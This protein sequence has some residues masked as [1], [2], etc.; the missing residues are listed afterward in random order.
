[1]PTKRLIRTLGGLHCSVGP[2]LGRAAFPGMAAPAVLLDD[3][4]AHASPGSDKKEGTRRQSRKRRSLPLDAYLIPRQS[5][6]S[7]TGSR[8][9]ARRQICY[10]TLIR[11][12]AEPGS[13][14]TGQ[15]CSA[16]VGPELAR[17]RSS[18]RVVSWL[19]RDRAQE[20]LYEPM[21]GN[22]RVGLLS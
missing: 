6:I 3:S 10:R 5:S 21:A 22:L 14:F 15:G 8:V 9:I 11:L 7:F 2:V 19:R 17:F 16:P 18:P 4:G 13:E 20:D 12:S 1:M